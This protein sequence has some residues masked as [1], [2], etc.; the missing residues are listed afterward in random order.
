MK[1]LYIFQFVCITL[2]ILFLIILFIP[3]NYIKKYV[4]NDIE[5]SEKYSK[6]N[7]NYYFTFKYNDIELDY[8]VESKYHIE[9]SLIKEVDIKKDKNNNFCIIPSSD[10]LTFVPLCYDNEKIVHYSFVNKELKSKLEANLFKKEK[11]IETYKDIEI[12]NQEYTYLLWNYDSFYYFNKDEKKKIDIFDKELYNINLIGY[13]KDYLVLADY[14]SNY[15]FNKMYTIDFKKGNLKQFNLDRN[16]YFDS[17]FIGYEKNRIYIVDNKEGLMYEWNA[18]NGEL[19]SIRSKVLKEGIWEN[20][21]I[22]TLLNKKETFTYKS[23][24][25]YELIDNKLY[26]DYKQDLKTLVD[27]NIKS[28]VKTDNEDIFYLKDSELYH[29][30]PEKGIEKLLNYFEWNFNFERMIYIY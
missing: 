20:V 23:N 27:T 24:F 3:K 21:S 25:H 8:L 15:T 14:D 2:F 29:F 6:K 19:E 7:K 9:R 30:S 16:I 13:T 26:L 12:Y 10:K 17:Y 11:L 4:I 28:I 22:K 1:R 5:I 18:K